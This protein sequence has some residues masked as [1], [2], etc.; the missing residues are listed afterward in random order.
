MKE[1]RP[2]TT[3]LTTIG[4]S[5]TAGCFPAA[6]HPLPRAGLEGKTSLAFL[7]S[8]FSFEKSSRY[9][10][11]LN[12]G[13]SRSGWPILSVQDPFLL[14]KASLLT[15]LT[16]SSTQSHL[17]S[18]VFHPPRFFLGPISSLVSP[19][20]RNGLVVALSTARQNPSGNSRLQSAGLPPPAPLNTVT[21]EA[22]RP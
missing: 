3:D 11:R 17:F 13:R 19:A 14:I 1:G 7:S 8:P 5:R 4:A 12:P 2:R 21:F 18:F 20:V 10:R 22:S 16:P 9:S 6:P 15:T